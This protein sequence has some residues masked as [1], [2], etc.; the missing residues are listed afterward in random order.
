MG[1]DRWVDVWQQQTAN[2]WLCGVFR[3]MDGSTSV[4]SMGRQRNNNKLR[5]LKM[6]V[7]CDAMTILY[8]KLSPSVKFFVGQSDSQSHIQKFSSDLSASRLLKRVYS[9]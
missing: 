5:E 1:K 9:V 7:R 3:W 6:K 4:C 8:H 2:R